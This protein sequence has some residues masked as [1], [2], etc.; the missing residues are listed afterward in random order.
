LINK[1]TLI[2]ASFSSTPGNNGCIFF[3][4]KF[5]KHNLNAIYKSFYSE[6]IK[7]SLDAA[8]ILKFSGFA[9]S[10]PFKFEI[11][12]FVDHLDDSVVKIGA[13]NTVIIINEKTYAYNTDWLAVQKYLH[14]NN[15]KKITILGDGGFSK[16][17][18]YACIQSD[19]FFDLITRSNWEDIK[20]QKG[21]LFNATPVEVEADNLIDGRPHTE[22]GKEIALLQAEEQFN[23]Y[24]SHFNLEV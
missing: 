21:T 15:V 7:Q 22:M 18:Q 19:I 14:T 5:E 13:A 24:T 16:A 3:N 1:D 6:D 23:L 11:T 12:N 9:V 4:N 8:K 10:M 17:V 2:F 20:N